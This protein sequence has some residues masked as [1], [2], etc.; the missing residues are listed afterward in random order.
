MLSC[1]RYFATVRRAMVTPC[2]ASMSVSFWSLN[3]FASSLWASRIFW[4]ANR[5]LSLLAVTVLCML[6]DETTCVE[7]GFR[8]AEFVKKYLMSKRPHSHW[9][10]LLL[11]IRD[12]V[13]SCTPSS[14]AMSCCRNG[15]RFP[16][17]FAKKTCCF[18]TMMQQA[19]AMVLSR[20]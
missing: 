1:E 19:R 10:Y 20:I 18:F 2:E 13:V 4:I 7:L 15:T 14:S 12:I 9:M 3:F 11:A 8:D 6:L 5:T 16:G 17:P